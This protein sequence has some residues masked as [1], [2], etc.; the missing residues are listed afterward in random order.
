MFARR[1]ADGKGF[2]VRAPLTRASGHRFE[3][4][5][6]GPDEVLETET[7]VAVGGQDVAA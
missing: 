3:R 2:P 7:E 4:V 6:G 1:V 5:A